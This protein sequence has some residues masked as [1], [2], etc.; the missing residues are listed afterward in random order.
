MKY[1]SVIIPAFNEEKN[2]KEC[3][4]SVLN[5][6]YPKDFYEI[7]VVDNNSCDRTFELA[8]SFPIKCLKETE[9]Q[10]PSAARNRGV[11]EAKG[12]IFAF[13]DADCIAHRRWLEEGIKKFKKDIGC[14]GGR[15]NATNPTN[16]FQK[17]LI[18]IG[19]TI[20][21]QD[22]PLRTYYYPYFPTLNVFYKREVFEKIGLFDTELLTGEDVDFCWRMQ[23]YTDYKMDFAPDAIVFH[24][25]KE[26]L[27][28]LF[29]QRKSYAK[30]RV[31]LIKKHSDKI[32]KRSFR[33]V[34][35][36]Y[37]NL[38]SS[39][40][41]LIFKRTLAFIFRKS[42]EFWYKE[43]IR[44]ILSLGTKLGHLEGS[45]KYRFFYP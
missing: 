37:F 45:L 3:I 34:Y 13:I 27:S 14:V 30:G 25:C 32:P 36:G 1:I 8:R 28:S 7:I 29:K 6:S 10:G 17:I 11:L 2:I 18:D 15:S 35:W 22:G 39:I 44:V 42:N 16:F 4:S 19:A 43:Y 23:F 24:K 20:G 9:I 31:L 38:L 26:S 5:Q 40:K 33:E 21:A 12:E 41:D